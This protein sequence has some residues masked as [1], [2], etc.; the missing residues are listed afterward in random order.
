VANGRPAR[1]GGDKG[2]AG[3]ARGK[4]LSTGPE[5]LERLAGYVGRMQGLSHDMAH[6]MKNVKI[7]IVD[8]K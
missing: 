3:G 1:A 6:Q 2:D 4:D 5:N 7:Y 8:L